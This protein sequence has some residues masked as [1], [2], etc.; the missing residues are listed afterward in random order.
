[1]KMNITKFSLLATALVSLMSACSQIPDEAYYNRGE[2]ESLLDQ[3]SEVVNFDLN[4]PSALDQLTQWVNQDQ[5]TRAELNCTGGDYNCSRAEQLLQQFGVPTVFVTSEEHSATLV[6][7]RVV[8][9]D[10]E[11][12]YVENAIN[13]YNLNHPTF[14]CSNSSNMVK[15][16]TDKRQLT[17]PALLG[18]P[19]AER[20][21]RVIDGYRQPYNASPVEINPNFETQFDL[22]TRTN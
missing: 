17:S 18:L 9:R 21:E 1:M 11:N 13:P 2:P 7:E 6:Y 22:N 3:S 12:R 19:D 8:A 10:C 4:S 5:P 15:M 16:I 14:G 20:A